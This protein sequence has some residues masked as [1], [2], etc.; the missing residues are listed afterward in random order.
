MQPHTAASAPND[1]VELLASFLINFPAGHSHQSVISLF[2]S[3]S[4][5]SPPSSSS[6]S[7]SSR[8]NQENHGA[9]QWRSK[10]PCTARSCPGSWWL[11]LVVPRVGFCDVLRDSEEPPIITRV[12]VARPRWE[13]KTAWNCAREVSS[14][15]G[16]E[17]VTAAFRN[18]KRIRKKGSLSSACLL[19]A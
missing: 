4:S 19:R 9:P 16:Q 2:S 13:A 11:A 5:S 10:S 1:H 7:P 3:S 17:E 18:N 12:G 14:V 6:S 8:T 15:A